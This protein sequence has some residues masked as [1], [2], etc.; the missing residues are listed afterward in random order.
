[1]LFR[2]FSPRAQQSAY[3]DVW[4]TKDHWSVM[5]GRKH[6]EQSG[7]WLDLD[8]FLDIVECLSGGHYFKQ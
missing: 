5:D 4:T 6:M 1:M 7:E 3:A 2:I 8:I